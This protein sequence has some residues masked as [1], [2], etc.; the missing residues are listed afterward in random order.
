MPLA[1]FA[2]VIF[3]DR[4]SHL[5]SPS[6]DCDSPIYASCVTG[7]TGMNHFTLFLLVV[8]GSHKIFAWAGLEAQS[9]KSLPPK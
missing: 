5:C 1:L 6:L 8:M 9:S 3:W 2:F 7:L 4:V